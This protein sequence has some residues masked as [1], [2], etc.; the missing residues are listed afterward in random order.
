[1]AAPPLAIVLGV[2]RDASTPG[3]QALAIVIALAVAF[4]VELAFW[5]L[6]GRRIKN[7]LCPPEPPKPGEV[8]WLDEHED[9]P[10]PSAPPIT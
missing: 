7:H 9:R 8:L 3:A 10:P 6:F 4:E 5:L 1:M 2:S